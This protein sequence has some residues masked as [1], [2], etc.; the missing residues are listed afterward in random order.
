M[1][2]LE[3]NTEKNYKLIFSII[4]SISLVWSFSATEFLFLRS[5]VFAFF[6]E[7]PYLILMLVLTYGFFPL[8]MFEIILKDNYK[9]TWMD[10]I[11]Y[12]LSLFWLGNFLFNETQLWITD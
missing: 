8:V 7:L 5:G 12:S 10:F 2:Q 6:G 4:I 3:S 1:K 9:F 11:Y